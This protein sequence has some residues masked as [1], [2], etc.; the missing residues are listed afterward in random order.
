MELRH[1]RGFI[2]VAEELHFARAAE[3]LHIEQSPLSR[4]I[5]ELES[6]IGA[7]LFDRNSRG[8]RLTHPGQVLAEAAQRIFQA[9]EQARC[10]VRAAAAG[11]RGTL[12]IALSDGVLPQRL[13]AV[14]ARCREEEPEVEIRLFEVSLSQQLRGLREDL[15]DVGFAR[16]KDVGEGLTAQAVWQMPL[17][18]A[19][20]ARHPLLAHKQ[21]QLAEALNYPLVLFHP[22]THRGLHQQMDSLLR[23]VP[24]S[25]TIVE[26][27]SSHE[28]MFSLVAAGYGIGLTCEAQ[29]ALCQSNDVVSRPLADDSSMLTSY[30]LRSTTPSGE[31]L[32]RFIERAT[33]LD[34]P[35]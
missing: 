14:L 19:V 11:Y 15:F 1:L 35:G 6:D 27:V 16:S 30:L 4:T 34:L 3:R 9:V 5:K 17:A 26:H 29:M 24:T 7:Q 33:D 32:R 12:R 10:N 13:S 28:V 8:T 2:A 25:P 22:Q 21:I 23:Q 31:Q 20:P 18:V